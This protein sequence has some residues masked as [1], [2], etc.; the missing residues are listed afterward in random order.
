M[1]ERR[2][3]QK[4]SLG[5]L[6]DK[7]IAG[8]QRVL[9]PVRENGR[10]AFEAMSSPEKLAL[11]YVHVERGEIEE[12]GEYDLE[13]LFVRLAYAIDSIGAKRVVL[14]TI[15]SL[16]AGLSNHAILRAELRRLFR[17][18]KSRGV[19]AI[20]TGERGDGQLTRHGLEEYVS[21]C[22]I[23]L[24][25]R[26]NEQVST[27]RLRIVKYRGTT[28][29]TNE[30]PFLIDQRGLGVLPVTSIGLSH[31]AL[32]KRVSSGIARLDAMLGAK[33]FYRGSS[34]LFSGTAGTGKTSYA[35]HFVDAACRRGERCIYCAFEESPA[36]IVRNMRSIGLDLEQW[37]TRGCL[38]FQ[39]AR[40]TLHGLEAHL[41]SIHRMIEELNPAHVVFDPITNL[42]TV[43]TSQEVRAMMM[44]LVDYLK[45]RHITTLFTSLTA[46][47]DALEATQIGLSSLMDTW[48][49]LRD[50]EV[51]GERNR[52]LHILKSR[53][54]AHSN[55]VREF[56]L[57]NHGVKLLD[58]YVGPGDPL[59]GSARLAQEAE[60]TA[61]AASRAHDIE[62]RRR[63]LERKRKALQAEIELLQTRHEAEE[64]EL[65]RIIHDGEQR[66]HILAQDRHRMAV[67]RKSDGLRRA[68]RQGSGD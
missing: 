29:G 22:V 67:S 36:Q 11:D 10:V 9:A 63:E 8:G 38:R 37:V 4:K 13:G 32:T 62:R 24:D 40:P 50:F 33:G 55:Q 26:V 46:G 43:G 53:G 65:Q 5:E 68:V 6:F 31:T 23:S 15:E 25:H 52:G 28:H 20:I 60:D 51:R 44:R 14:D 18:L 7:L 59:T 66:E 57:T 12:T 64:D 61:T 16:F 42:V 54:M 21:D 17:W 56:L 47:G 39:S 3:L 35:A 58:P 2:I 27:R 19:T 34:V 41:T 48:L 49:L 45:L 30:Y 1:S